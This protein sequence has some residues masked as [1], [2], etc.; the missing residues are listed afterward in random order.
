MGHVPPQ[1]QHDAPLTAVLLRALQH[2]LSITKPGIV[3]G[4]LIAASGGFFL[5]ARGQFDAALFL[6]TILG[7]SLIVGAGCV[8]N[9]CIDCDIDAKMMRTRNRVLPQGAMRIDSALSYALLLL[10]SGA[11]LLYTRV[12]ITALCLALLGFVIYVGAYSLLFKRRSTFGTLI[13]SVAGAMPPVIGYCAISGQ[14]NLVAFSLLLLFCLWQ[15]PHFYA[16]TLFRRAD[17]LAA[18]IPLLPVETAKRQIVGYIAAF[19]LCALLP[20]LSGATGWAYLAVMS[21]VNV[22][23]LIVALKAR[24]QTD[25]AADRRWARRVFFCSIVVVGVLSLMIAIDFN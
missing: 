7:A 3:L 10:V 5:A 15:M 14:F 2:G 13:G 17:Y 1:C 19:S 22:G 9:N 23:W 18:G 20:V 8:C 11:A 24:G 4:N 21:V 25:A 6:A 16:I 12:N